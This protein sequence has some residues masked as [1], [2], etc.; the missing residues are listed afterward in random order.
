MF[1]T[2]IEKVTVPPGSTDTGEAVLVTSRSAAG[3]L[4]SIAAIA[5][6]F[7]LSGSGVVELAEATLVSVWPA[8]AAAALTVIVAVAVLPT[9]RV[10]TGQVTTAPAALH[11]AVPE[12]NVNPAGRV[13]VIAVVAAGLGPL[14]TSVSVKLVVSAGADRAVVGALL[15]LEVGG[16]DHECVDRVGGAGG[17]GV[18]VARVDP[19]AVGHDRAGSG[20]G[21][22]AGDRD[23]E[24][25]VG[26]RERRAGAHDRERAAAGGRLD[27][28]AEA[29]GG[30][31]AWCER[32]WKRIVDAT[33]VAVSGPLLLIA[34][35]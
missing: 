1:S 21:E 19:G 6:P 27:D 15:E 2:A 30:H 5:W 18:E 32:G 22:G 7:E 12:T 10:P 35:V 24:R 9:G 33:L 13:S 16:G 3:F 14:L 4:T 28:A 20:G 34:R 11:P 17:V 23:R 25:A 26:D 8:A 29:W 31:R